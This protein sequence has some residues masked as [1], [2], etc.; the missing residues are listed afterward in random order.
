VIV[1]TLDDET[2]YLAPSTIRFRVDNGIQSSLILCAVD[3]TIRQVSNF[4]YIRGPAE[5]VPGG[6]CCSDTYVA[7]RLDYRAFPGIGG[8]AVAR[9][10]C[11]PGTPVFAVIGNEMGTGA[12]IEI[13][14]ANLDLA[15]WP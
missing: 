14:G 12:Q 3:G 2:F 8:L 10:T 13:D 7:A 9:G 15:L 4:E 1:T 6:N 11:T 5:T